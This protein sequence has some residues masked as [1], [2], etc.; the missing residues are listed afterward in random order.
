MNSEEDNRA[1]EIN[2]INEADPAQLKG[3]PFI[4]GY[5]RDATAVDDYTETV[6]RMSPVARSLGETAQ[7]QST[8]R[9]F[10]SSIVNEHTSE[11]QLNNLGGGEVSQ[12]TNFNV[13]PSEEGKKGSYNKRQQLELL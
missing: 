7:G 2:D 11:A 6:A 4:T 3:K 10:D 5:K 12:V 13:A 8:E 9:D 1:K